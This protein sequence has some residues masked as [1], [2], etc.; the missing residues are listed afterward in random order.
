MIRTRNDFPQLLVSTGRTKYS[1]E[2]GVAEGYF[3]WHLLDHWPGTHYLVDP[4]KRL[5][6][7]GYSVHGDE[8]QEAR[9][10]R[11]LKKANTYKGRAIVERMTS[12][13]A[14]PYFV[15]NFFD[16][17]Y[18]DANHTFEEVVKD[19]NLWWPKVRAGGILAGH[20]YLQG[21]KDGVIYGV[22]AAVDMFAMPDRL[23][24]GVTQE[25][26]YKSWWIEKP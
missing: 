9:Y 24:V 19:I 12:E 7:P 20:D 16:F 14:A 26:D 25:E 4:W 23:K 11:I 3:S 17:V 8:D 2:I 22:K 1:V 15:D 21:L 13:K 18:I 5:S 6:V 10:K